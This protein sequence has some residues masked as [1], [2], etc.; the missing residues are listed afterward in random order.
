VQY[1]S[2]TEE[3]QSNF[4]SI[5]LQPQSKFL[6]DICPTDLPT[7][8]QLIVSQSFRR[9]TSVPSVLALVKLASLSDFRTGMMS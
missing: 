5:F 6:G 9:K 8:P 3:A 7:I 2:V 1:I 4:Q